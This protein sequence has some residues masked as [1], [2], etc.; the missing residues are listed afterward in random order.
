MSNLTISDVTTDDTLLE[1]DQALFHISGVNMTNIES[2]TFLMS[3][4]SDSIGSIKYFDGKNIIGP[5]LHS[6]NCNV[7]ISDAQFRNI[8]NPSSSSGMF[9]FSKSSALISKIVMEKITVSI[10]SLH[11]QP[12]FKFNQATKVSII[13]L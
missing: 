5:L 7:T 2:S 10:L 4:N 3:F 1:F 9:E 8:Y 12:I 13:H 11:S 6:D